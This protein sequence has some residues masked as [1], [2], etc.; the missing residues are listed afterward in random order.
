[1]AEFLVI[2]LGVDREQAASWIAVDSNGTRTSQPVTG[3]LA[4]AALDVGDRNVIVLVPA[5]TVLTTTVVFTLSMLLFLRP[6]SEALLYPHNLE[7]FAIVVF[8]IAFDAL[9]ALPFARLR[10]DNRPVRFA[11]IKTLNII[12]NIIF[13]FL[14][15]ELNYSVLHICYISETGILTHLILETILIFINFKNTV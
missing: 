13:V 3:P 1:M 6:I 5:T 15:L 12:V 9:A 4:S 14:F 10:L 7:Y 11:I 2:R 8:I